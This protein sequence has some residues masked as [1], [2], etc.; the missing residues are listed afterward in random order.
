MKLPVK[1]PAYLGSYGLL[2]L[3][4]YAFY[5]QVRDLGRVELPASGHAYCIVSRSRC[6]LQLGG[7]RYIIEVDRRHHHGL[8]AAASNVTLRAKMENRCSGRHL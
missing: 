7:Q 4:P 2:G 3:M 6:Q 5:L 8:L 1:V